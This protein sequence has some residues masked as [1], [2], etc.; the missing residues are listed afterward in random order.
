MERLPLRGIV[1]D[2]LLIERIQSGWR[3]EYEASYLPEASSMTG[4]NAGVDQAGRDDIG[5]A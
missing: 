3:A 2:T 5:E 1:N 4:K